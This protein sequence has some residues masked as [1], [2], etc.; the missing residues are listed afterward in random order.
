M[1]IYK[2]YSFLIIIALF[3]L[4]YIS[5]GSSN[6]DTEYLANVLD[7]TYYGVEMIIGDNLTW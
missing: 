3:G 5:I 1:K 6:E 4:S 7:N 2:K